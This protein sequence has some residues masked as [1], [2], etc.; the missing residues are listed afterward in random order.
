MGVIELLPGNRVKLRISRDFHWR[1]N[2][3][4]QR[5]FETRVQSEFLNARFDGPGELRLFQ[6]GMLSRRSHEE[7]LQRMERLVSEFNRLHREDEA[8]P[9]DQ[10]FGVSLVLATRPWEVSVFDQLRREPNTKRYG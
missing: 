8:L 3:P 7:M 4:I 2:G 6:S 9:L 5:F 1:P 10:R